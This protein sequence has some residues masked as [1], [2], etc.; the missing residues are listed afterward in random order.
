M[1]GIARREENEMTLDGLSRAERQAQ[2]RE[3]LIDV[4]RQQF[5]KHGYAATSLDK[6]AIEAGFS[7][8]AVYS[9]F[10]GKEELCMAVL[11]EIHA[12]QTE[13]VD[14]AFRAPG[15]LEGKVKALS[16]WAHNG[17]GTPRWTAMEVD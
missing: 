1:C 8:G 4:A 13:A 12:E 17:V 3:R 14:D 2:T 7:K 11:D 16:T 10:A 6:V 15:S 9:N 5:L